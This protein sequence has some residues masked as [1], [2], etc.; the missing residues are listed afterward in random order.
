METNRRR[1]KIDDGNLILPSLE[2]LSAHNS[3]LAVATNV[4]LLI[5]TVKSSVISARLHQR[6]E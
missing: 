1:L 3:Q 5:Q 2:L 6:E 4:A